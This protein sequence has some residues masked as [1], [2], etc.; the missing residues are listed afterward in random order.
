MP[1]ATLVNFAAGETSPKSRGRFDLDWFRSSCEKVLNFI[2]ELA[3]PAR[4]RSGFRA[5]R[6]TRAGAVARLVPFQVNDTQ[7]YMLEFTDSKMRVYKDGELLTV[8]RT[9]VTA[10]TNANPA[11]ITVAATTSLA[12]GDEVIITDIV[13]MPELNNR[14]VKLTNG[15]GLTFELV[16][17]TTGGNVDSTGL[18]VYSSGG[19]LVE[20]YEIASPYLEDELD[21]IQFAQ[22]KNQMYLVNPQYAPYKLTVDSNDAFTLATYSRTNDPFI[23]SAAITVFLIFRGGQTTAGIT[24]AS[25][26]TMVMFVDGSVINQTILYTFSGVGGTTQINGGAYLLNTDRTS[27]VSWAHPMA[28]LTNADG[29]DVNSDAWTAYTS[30]GVATPDAEHPLW[31]AFYESR[32]FFVGTNQRPNSV[33]GSR[34]PDD[35]DPRYD[36]FTGGTDADHA[37]FFTLAPANGKVDYIS[38]GRGTSKYL[39]VGTFG[40]PFRVSGGGLDE[41][42]T[43]S[44]INVR[45]LDLVGCEVGTP[46][47]GS[48]LFFIQRG[49]TAL[50]TLRYNADIDDF[51]T[52]DMLLN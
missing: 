43:P 15:S 29:S 51:E 38:W 35:E 13:G 41:P 8:D 47:G 46:V 1:N 2:V 19:T 11:V 52:Q 28:F 34:A 30:G 22:S 32:L 5:I 4:Y 16:D 36:D 25:G 49:G 9:T 20:I 37:V 21:D 14:Q 45:Q 24:V 23:A 44:S 50:R 40:G 17:P 48:R 39:F 31:V 27:S 18:G 7:A 42:I 12:N 6:Q 3:G 26:K 10:I 33:F